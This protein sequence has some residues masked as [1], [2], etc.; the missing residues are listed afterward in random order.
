MTLPR[1]AAARTGESRPAAA[2]E[3]GKD[4]PPRT[5]PPANATADAPSP[6]LA[7]VELPPPS[8]AAAPVEATPPV[9]AAVWAQADPGVTP[10]LSPAPA[11]APP[12]FGDQAGEL[13]V[14][15]TAPVAAA[16]TAASMEAAGSSSSRAVQPRTPAPAVRKS[17]GSVMARVLALGGHMPQTVEPIAAVVPAA[18]TVEEQAA[19]RRAP[20]TPAPATPATVVAPDAVQNLAG[21]T[22]P[23]EAHPPQ[24]APT[25]E[26]PGVYGHASERR[27][28]TPLPLGAAHAALESSYGDAAQPAGPQVRILNAASPDRDEVAFALQLKAT[29]TPEGALSAVSPSKPPA[30]GEAPSVAGPAQPAGGPSTPQPVVPNKKPEPAP[31]AEAERVPARGARERRTDEAPAA[32]IEAS[33]ATSAAKPVPPASADTQSRTEAAPERADRAPSEPARPPDGADSV[34]KPDTAQVHSVRDM[35][36]EV[37]GGERRVEVRVSERA[38]EVKMT[39][40]TPDAPLATTLRENLPALS[41]RLSDSGLKSE[42]WHPAASSHDEWRHTA[43]PAEGG[44]SQDAHSQPR[45]QGEEP[46]DGAGQ[47]RPRSTQQAPS[48]KEKGKDFAWL[49]SSLR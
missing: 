38:G 44:A 21:S 14:V 46:Q 3:E 9:Q 27:A 29:P 43:R 47:R 5:E 42:A 40:R 33:P 28:A 39:V 20:E 18:G 17:S 24:D 30:G 22:P 36:F 15:A 26:R 35:K 34:V 41:A 6:R 12:R 16:R 32:H 19:P 7:G 23:A 1:T 37:T 10:T 31:A 4:S 2:P 13:P 48:A 11:D 45:Q 8:T 49:M 25:V